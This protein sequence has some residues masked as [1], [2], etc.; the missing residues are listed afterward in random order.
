MGI[1]DTLNRYEDIKGDIKFVTTSS[2]RTKI[3]LSLNKGNKDLNTLKD[4][5][6]LESSA[7]LHALKKLESQNMIVKKENEYSLSSVG[8]LYAVKSSNLFKSF[9]TIKKYEKIWLNHG[10]DG[11]P[12]NLLKE[13]KCLNNSFLVE[14]TPTD[15]IKPHSHYAELVTKAHEIKSISPIFYYPYI[16]LY[17]NAL[18][19][20]AN[21]KL[22]L[23]PLILA[24]LTE[25]AGVEILNEI[26]SSKKF[27]LYKTN[28]DTKI[29]LTVTENFLS[30]GLFST[31]GL[32]DATITLISYDA[33]AIEWGNK[34]FN[35]YLDKAREFNL[36]NLNK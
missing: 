36:D 5:L 12:R 6:D 10:I 33:D 21:V 26:L 14:S 29:V 31:E 35:Y 17:K 25:T 19:R 22:I 24:K 1:I 18:K 16:D 7:A 28:E 4:E 9:Y 34:L 13:I 15:I 3:I 30:L 8:R 11:I 20:N 2:V 23:T 27:K 32:Y